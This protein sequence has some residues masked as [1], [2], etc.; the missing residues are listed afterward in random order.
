VLLDFSKAF[1][2]VDH[3]LLCLKL[4]RIYGFSG[5]AVSFIESY[6][7]GRFQCVCAG[8]VLSGYLPVLNGVPQGS[9]LGLLF[10]LFINDLC[11][12]IRTSNY[13]MYAEDKSRT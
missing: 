10:F 11:E 4:G 3:A 8:G 7:S 13:H 9:I 5:S 2:T 6:L 12:A 1:D